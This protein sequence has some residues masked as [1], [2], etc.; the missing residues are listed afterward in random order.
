MTTTNMA[1]LEDIVRMDAAGV[2]DGVIRAKL[3]DVM[4]EFFQ[5]TSSWL[6]EIYVYIIPTTND[7]QLET[8][9]NV[10]VDRLMA[11]ERPRSPPPAT[12]SPSAY[13]PMCPPQ[14]LPVTQSMDQPYVESQNPLFRTPRQGALLTSG[15]KCPILRIWDNPSMNETWIATLGLNICD[16]VDSDGFVEPPDW[17]M[18]KYMRYI[19]SGVLSQLMTQPG[20]PYSSLPG[21]Q[22]H[23]RRFLRGISQCRED[24]RHMFIYGGQRWGFPGGWNAPRPRLPSSYVLP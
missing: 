5:A 24:V 16:P 3:F 6:L 1:R 17:I 8:G 10:V 23:G 12:G 9:Q 20:K 14:F 2:L 22:Y 18:E 19:A 21:A 15:V 13:L 7:Y 11:L 4:K